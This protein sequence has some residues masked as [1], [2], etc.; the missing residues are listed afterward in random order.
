MISNPSGDY[1]DRAI[2]HEARVRNYRDRADLL[3]RRDRD[4]DCAGA[5]LYEA[6]KQCINAVANQRGANPG[7]TGG[8]V[9]VL[10][11]IVLEERDGRVLFRNWQS[12][13]KLHIHADRGN[14]T[15][16]AFGEHRAQ[17]QAFIVAMLAI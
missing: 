3:L 11:E 7:T 17:T 10:R 2:R 4:I 8:K 5:L 6:A 15:V 1:R 14:L 12:A 13:D 16:S 9:R